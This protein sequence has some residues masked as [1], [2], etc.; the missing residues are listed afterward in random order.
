M[1]LGSTATDLR[2]DIILTPSDGS[3]KVE[4]MLADADDKKKAWQMAEVPSPDG[5]RVTQY[6]AAAQ[7]SA[8]EMAAAVYRMDN[9]QGMGPQII[10]VG[11]SNYMS[12]SVQTS[13]S[14]RVIQAPYTE[15]I[16][17]AATGEGLT[18]VEIFN[19]SLYVANASKVFRSDDGL[20]FY[21]TLDVGSDTIVQLVTY[22]ADDGDPGIIC[23]LE[24]GEYYYSLTGA[25][26]SWDQAASGYNF[27]RMAIQN[28][29]LWGLENPSTLR[30]TTDPYAA[31]PVWSG[32]TTIGDT[33]HNFKNI[34]AVANFL[35]IFKED[36]IVYAVSTNDV[37]SKALSQFEGI[38]GADNFEAVSQGF[39][40]NVYF[41]MDQDVWEYDPASGNT[42][43]LHLSKLPDTQIDLTGEIS[44]GITYDQ[45]GLYSIHESNIGGT[46]GS[47]IVRTDFFVN[48]QFA[49]ERWLVNTPSGYRP[50]GPMKFTR[51]FTGLGTG[52]HVWFGLHD[53]TG[54]NTAFK[55]GRMTVPRAS[56]PTQ[57][58]LS[59]FSVVDGIYRSG[60]MHHN[61]PAQFKD[62]TEVLLDMR[63]LSPVAPQASV[64]VYY[65]IDGDLSTRYTLAENL[66]SNKLQSLEFANGI[67]ARTFLLELILHNDNPAT[68]PQVISW[69][70]KAAVK[71]D[72]REVFT[73]AIRVGDKIA[74]RG[75]NR[76][77]LS[78]REIRQRIRQLRRARDITIRYQDYRGYDF[79]N[80]RILTGINEVDEV[81]DAARTA[82]TIMTLRIMRVSEPFLHQFHVAQS[83]VAGSDV[84]GA[85]L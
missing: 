3:P 75:K 60:W 68:T 69:N 7:D 63:G 62:Y 45:Q 11:D 35:I 47:T 21:E 4:L 80:V 79:T 41:T 5:A 57:D 54:A 12:G 74:M 48:G 58:S 38:P 28:N 25:P 78:A 71:F 10:S 52:R 15:E 30:L 2:A 37:V 84:V 77:P 81:D 64:S 43:P 24:D 85:A 32:S 17:V 50:H 13:V 8:P 26:T 73:V 72:F 36:G 40:S 44:Q 66:T 82:E 29:Q 14:G 42:Q 34:L 22:G 31:A 18:A 59:E 55:I 9:F 23:V 46:T 70:V 33:M 53:P 16:T 65:Y 83:V 20:L 27:V 51:M 1:P 6:G 61:F 19:G 49:H 76:S 67:T 39:D 56:D